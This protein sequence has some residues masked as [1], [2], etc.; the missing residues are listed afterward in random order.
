MKANRYTIKDFSKQFPNDEACLDYL[1]KARYPQGVDCPVC[2]KVTKHYR[3]A[4]AK[5]YV[6]EFCGHAVSP[7]ANT[8]FHKSTT[9]LRFWFYAM[10]L[11]VSTRCG[12]SA[13][14]LERELGVTYKTAWKIFKRIRSLM[15]EEA[16][17]ANEHIEIDQAYLSR[18]QVGSCVRG[19]EEKAPVAEMVR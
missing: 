5:D 18:K 1:F 9:P 6:C 15:D 12:I 10:L 3:R 19:V 13:K 11:M 4:G 2:Q 8:I 17:P 16:E 14:Q 7:T